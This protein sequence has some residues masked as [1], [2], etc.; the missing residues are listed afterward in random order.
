MNGG[1]CKECFNS[2]TSDVLLL[3]NIFKWFYFK[4]PNIVQ[5][6]KSK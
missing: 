5:R 3:L 1:S 4:F 2:K 6:W